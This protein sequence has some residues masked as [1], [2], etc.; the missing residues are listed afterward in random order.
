MKKMLGM[1]ALVLSLCMML[2]VGAM[3]DASS[4]PDSAAEAKWYIQPESVAGRTLYYGHLSNALANSY[5]EITLQNDVTGSFT[6][7]VKNSNI[8]VDLNGKI[9]SPETLFVQNL[10]RVTLK[11]GTVFCPASSAG[12]L[13]D[14]GHLNLDNLTFTAADPSFARAVDYNS[15]TIHYSG[16]EPLVIVTSITLDLQN[17]KIFVNADGTKDSSYTFYSYQTQEPVT[18][19]DSAQ[20]G[21]TYWVCPKG[22][23]PNFPD[24][25]SGGGGGGVYGGVYVNDTKMGNDS[26][27]DNDGDY[28]SSKPEGGYAHYK[29]GV[30][31]LNNFKGEEID[32]DDVDVT[33]K[34]IGDNELINESQDTLMVDDGDLIIEGAGATLRLTTEGDNDEAL[35]IDGGNLTI[36]G[37]TYY[38]TT[39]DDG[40]EAQDSEVLIEN[41][42]MVITNNGTD[43]EEGIDVESDN[44]E[45]PH[46]L[47]IR[48]SDITLTVPYDGINVEDGKTLIENTALTITSRESDGIDSYGDLTIR[49]SRL[50]ISAQESALKN[51]GKMTLI[52][53]ELHL[54]SR[55]GHLV[56]S[57]LEGLNAPDLP[58]IADVYNDITDENVYT[59][60][61]AN[62]PFSSYVF[63]APSALKPPRTGD[64]TPIALLAALCLLSLTGAVILRKRSA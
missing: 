54:L 53:N 63:N 40:I 62:G 14:G 58:V 38:F 17:E 48:N 34:L 57:A 56:I 21:N 51:D 33:L 42:K 5:A 10:S 39:L 36:R 44:R 15:G 60:G 29:D 9:L 6:A 28:S 25:G 50:N 59:I 27:I 43:D 19:L 41:A 3:A 35:D 1:L 49:G 12:I 20:Y 4:T 31:T 16:N 7:G 22:I 30:L 32:I 24:S 18:V 47:T 11:N 46:G 2:P 64:S 26:Y 23:T 55:S 37:G 13:L 8:T 61:D 45:Q 52:A